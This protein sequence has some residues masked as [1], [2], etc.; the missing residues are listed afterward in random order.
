M[1]HF[2][3]SFL[4]LLIMLFVC[5]SSALA[6]KAVAPVKIGALSC[7]T[8]QPSA[9]D[10]KSPVTCNDLCGEQN[11]VC[12]GVTSPISPAQSCEATASQWS[13]TCRCCKAVSS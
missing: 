1:R 11:A 2:G 8:I 7:F 5:G 9:H 3:V 12:T 4:C 13:T 10:P 6:E